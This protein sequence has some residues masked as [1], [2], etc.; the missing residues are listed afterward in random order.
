M[1]VRIIELSDFRLI[2]HATRVP[3]IYEGV[4][5]HFERHISALPATEHER[6]KQ[7][8]N[9]SPA[10]LLQ[11]SD[12]LAPDDPEGTELTYL[13]GVAV[14]SAT[15][16]PEDLDATHVPARTWAAFRTSGEHPKALQD[17]MAATASEWFPANPWQLRPGPSV[18]S[19]LDRSP[20]F[21]TATCEVWYPV[22]RM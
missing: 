20:D 9:T 13:H 21:S 4:N 3:L 1:D 10:G 12:D 15:A 14:N 5:P 11:V 2:G 7:L 17:A 22:E 16:L 8:S 6:L 19:I 18:V